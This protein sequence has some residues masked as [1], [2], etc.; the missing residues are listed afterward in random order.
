M[1]DEPVA[2]D[3][4][5]APAA[6]DEETEL[7]A[8]ARA[9]QLSDGFSLLFARCNEPQQ[10]QRLMASLQAELRGLVVQEIS[11]RAP[12]RHLLDALRGRLADP[13]P[14]AVF[15]SGLENSLPLAAKA[16]AAP[17]VANLNAAR[18]S[19]PLVLPCPLVLWVPDYVLTAI[20]HGA[21]DF[22]SIRSG[23]YYFAA[24][25]VDMAITLDWLS[26]GGSW[27]LM[28][29]SLEEKQE[30]L[31][32]MQSLLSEFGALP[33]VQRERRTEMRLHGRIGSLLWSL[34]LLVEAGAQYQA[35][36]DL[37]REL[38][39]RSAE[40]EA[41]SHLGSVYHQQRRLEEAET[42][43]QQALRLA[44]EAGSLPGEVTALVGVGNVYCLLGRWLEAGAMYREGAALAR[45]S[46]DRCGEE[47]ALANLGSIL[48]QQGRPAEAEEAYQRALA[49][50]REIGDR[51]GEGQILNNLGGARHEQGRLPEAETAYQES[52]AIAREIGNAASERGTL[53]NLALLYR[54]L[55]RLAE[56]EQCDLRLRAISELLHERTGEAPPL[57]GNTPI[58]LASSD[59]EQ[60]AQI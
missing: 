39:D 34:D 58:P 8:L 22:F 59:T 20:L 55:G 40:S 15:V 36:L 53:T 37:A 60:A 26:P 56:A 24:A 27:A 21:P 17:F 51:M 42:A 49:M 35:E 23:V 11:F 43:Y 4:P 45:E 7:R 57:S 33:P 30:R 5:F 2:L 6:L 31:A 38:G 54:D 50:A 18:N 47:A 19:F 12:I 25:P 44:R 28:S 52:L 13:P 9:L 46:G 3:H 29:M 14:G 10:R 48:D 32:S 1:S 16:D 41:M